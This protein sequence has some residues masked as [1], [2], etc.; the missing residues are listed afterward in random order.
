MGRIGLIVIAIVVVLAVGNTFYILPEQEQAIITQFGEPIGDP[1]TTPGLK[2]KVPLFHTVHRFEKRF[3]E[4]DGSPNQLPTKDKRFIWV[5]TYARWRITDP[6]KFFQRLRDERGARTRLDDI[7]D[8]ETRNAIANSNLVEVIRSTNREPL[9]GEL[10][11][12]DEIVLEKI[13]QGREDVRKIVLQNAQMRT[14]D[15]GIEILDVQFKRINYVDEVRQTV[16]ARMISER[17]RIAERFRSEGQGEASRIAGERERELKRIQSEAT[18]EER[19]I[20]GDA[21]AAVTA[22]YAAAYDR[23]ADTRSFYEFIKSMETLEAA[24]DAETQ[25][26]FTTD[27]EFWKYLESSTGR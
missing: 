6:L 2:L 8:G 11:V 14:A 1:K 19:E 23:N 12:E 22:I 4:W 7:L 27:G 26:L 21:D 3:L 25:L 16:Y 5:D 9:R 15:L 18:R 24:V 20:R 13:S 17:K 10:L